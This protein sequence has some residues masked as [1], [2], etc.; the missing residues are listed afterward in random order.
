M[1]N[2]SK[3][4]WV[5]FGVA[6]LAL[7]G[8]S[9]YAY[10]GGNLNTNEGSIAQE[11]VQ[12]FIDRSRADV[13]ARVG[14]PIEGFEPFMFMRAYAGLTAQDF[15]NVDALIGLYRYQNGQ[16][17]Y[18]LN[19]EQELHSAARAI[20][21]EGMAELLFNISERLNIDLE[22]EGTLEDIFAAID[23]APGP[24][25]TNGNGAAGSTCLAGSDEPC[26]DD[27]SQNPVVPGEEATITGTMV[28]LPHKGDGPHTL[29]CAYGLKGDDGKHYALKNLFT[30][31][32]PWPIDIGDR[33]RVTG[34]MDDPE[35]NEKYDIVAVIDV[36]TATKI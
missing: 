4:F 11:T 25:P 27:P 35:L 31:P 30:E 6:V 16:V 33:V 14:Q 32:G 10:W 2:M 9:S 3:Q 8:V 7:V 1:R 19:G 28:C 29:E 20:S 12:E 21:D 36:Q 13:I 24:D 15:D 22:D 17:V 26:A 34:S 23:T 18:D 5:G